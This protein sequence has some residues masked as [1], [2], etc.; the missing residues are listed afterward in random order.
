MDTIQRYMV[1]QMGIG[2]MIDLEAFADLRFAK[3]ACKGTPKKGA[4]A[5]IIDQV[6]AFHPL[7][8]DSTAGQSAKGQNADKA[9]GR[10]GLGAVSAREGKYLTFGIGEER[11]GVGILDVREIVGMMP[12]RTIPQVPEFIKGVVNLRGKV[13]PVI[14][15]R[16]KFGMASMA[17]SDR[18]CIIIVEVSGMTGS[19]LMGIVV[20]RVL[21]VAEF[22]EQEIEDCPAFGASFKTD[23]ILG[24][25]KREREVTMLLDI[26]RILQAEDKV[27]LVRGGLRT[28]NRSRPDPPLADH[29]VLHLRPLYK[30]RAQPQGM[31][32][33]SRFA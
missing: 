16:L 22:K 9:P 30:R 4:G 8:G 6:T 20:D 15:M 24:I 7:K 1:N 23:F 28:E 19:T 31:T 12:I 32:P 11:Y 25:A 26:Y 27:Y 2:A 29:R 21:E 33:F 3:E 13:I 5:L 18:T 14:D 17:Y 10:E